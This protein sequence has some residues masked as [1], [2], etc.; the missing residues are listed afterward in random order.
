M[1]TRCM[2]QFQDVDTKTP[3][4]GVYVH[5]D[6]YPKNIVPELQEFF[7]EVEKQV[8]HDT[9]FHDSTMLASRYVVWKANKSRDGENMLDFLNVRVVSPDGDY[10]V[11]YLYTVRCDKTGLPVVTHSKVP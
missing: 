7:K 3:E 10:G 2:I 9:R 6:G 1:S 5:W 4:S 8:P 11:D